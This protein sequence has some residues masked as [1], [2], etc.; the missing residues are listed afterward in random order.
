MDIF[1]AIFFDT[2]LHLK[3]NS[4]PTVPLMFM[5][6]FPIKFS[7]LVLAG[8]WN[9]LGLI[10]AKLFWLCVRHLLPHSSCLVLT[11]GVLGKNPTEFIASVSFLLT[12]RENES[13]SQSHQE[14][15][16]EQIQGATPAGACLQRGQETTANMCWKWSV[17]KMPCCTENRS[18]LLWALNLCFRSVRLRWRVSTSWSVSTVFPNKL[19]SDWWARRPPGCQRGAEPKSSLW[20]RSMLLSRWWRRE[21]KAELLHEELDYC[22]RF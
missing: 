12:W 13:S 6:F 3:E 22:G 2:F 18:H 5:F 20:R 9:Q 7:D 8:C 1:Y 16:E 11:S 15:H 4:F 19:R 10:K 21:C 17:L 14:D